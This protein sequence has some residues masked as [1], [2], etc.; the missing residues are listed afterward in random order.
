MQTISKWGNSLAVRI[1]AAA[2]DS[3]GLGE[4]SEVDISVKAGALMV[5]PAR[6]RR[7]D[8]KKLVAQITPRNRHKLA[9]WGKPVG[10]EV[11]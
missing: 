1:P 8:L 4:G 3:V 9:D 2:A 7:Y 6:N 5:A 11:W 10:K